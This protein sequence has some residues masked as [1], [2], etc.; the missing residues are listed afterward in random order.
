VS[1]TE[2]R[3]EAAGI[4]T[5]VL[6]SGQGPPLLL[7]H[8]PG[9]F[10]AGWAPVLPELAT[11]HHV[12]VPDLPGHGASEGLDRLDAE[13][14]L[15]WLD[16]LIEVTCS[17]PPTLVGRTLGGAIA[18]RFALGQP[19]RV[20]RLVLVDTLGLADFSPAPRFELVLT[21][22]LREPSERSYDRLMAECLYDLDTVRDR[23]GDGWRPFARYAIDLARTESVQAATM[24]LLGGFGLAAMPATEL[25]SIAVPT[26]LIWGRDDLATSLAVAEEAS[27]RYAWPL[28]V[29]D[30]AGDDPALEQP[31]AFCA[32][33]RSALTTAMET[34]ETIGA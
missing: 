27:T 33:L 17:G 6:E 10:A 29:I 16:D 19:H 30:D 15:A 3:V 26:T 31:E 25:A 11:T 12:V 13:R 23:M 4:S 5:A 8:G 18:A 21:R 28:H 20:D 7:L 22:F 14:V 2:R 1:A 32:A 9:E 34:E 24:A